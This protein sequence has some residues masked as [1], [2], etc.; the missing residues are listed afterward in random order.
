MTLV[1][2]LGSPDRGDDG[3]GPE[4]AD[5]VR[6]RR[7]PGVRVRVL[8][9]PSRLLEAWA[10]DEDVVVVDAVRSGDRPAGTVVAVEAGRT[11]VTP[12]APPGGPGGTHA[13]GLADVVRL[14][15]EVD[16]L[17]RRL[18]VVGVVGGTFTLGAGL[19]EPVRA[20][21]DAA[22]AVVGSRTVGG[23]SRATGYA[24]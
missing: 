22:V 24:R 17:P 23:P 18:L 19:S 5:R 1:L 8:A 13:V 4:V 10:D 7:L 15:R 11:A 21:L 6:A 3:V 14:A 2:G 20:A 9:D 16:A 12:L